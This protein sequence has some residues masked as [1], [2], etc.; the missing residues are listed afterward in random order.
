MKSNNIFF[1]NIDV[2]RGILALMVVYSHTV[3]TS[4]YNSLRHLGPYSVVWL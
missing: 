3:T 1:G 2:L 4:P